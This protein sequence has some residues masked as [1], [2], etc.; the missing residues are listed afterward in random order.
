MKVKI[1]KDKIFNI[2][3][4]GFTMFTFLPLLTLVVMVIK[5]GIS[6]INLEFFISTPKPP[7]ETGG[8][9]INGI[10]GTFILI[11]LASLISIPV[12]IFIGLFLYEF[13]NIK[14]GRLCSFFVNILYS[15]P[16]IVIGIIGYLWV[17]K[18]MGRFSAFSGAIALSLIFLPLI[19]KSTEETLKMLP[20]SLVEAS[21]ALGISYPKTVFKVLLPCGAS[22]ILAGIFT[23]I[24]RIAGETAPLLFTAFGNP[25][26]NINIFKPIS[27][28]SHIIFTY[29]ISPYEEWHKHAYGTALVLIV[30]V[31]SLSFLSRYFVRKR[32]I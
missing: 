4:I 17:V 29:A 14:F 16:S 30:L 27:S 21:L 26:I 18:P 6:A 13:R 31:I 5:N 1:V 12:G 25:F 32:E 8:G 24:A 9:I 20:I 19:I 11:F 10:I 28:L 3:I 2:L 22:G 15:I 7:G 23:G